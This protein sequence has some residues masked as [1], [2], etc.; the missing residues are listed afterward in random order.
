MKIGDTV[1][2]IRYPELG[3]GIIEK[4]WKGGCGFF[5]VVFTEDPSV[6]NLMHKSGLEIA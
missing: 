3:V 1:I 4:S 2:S 5:V 6:T